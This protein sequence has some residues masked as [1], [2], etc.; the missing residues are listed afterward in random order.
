MDLATLGR[1]ANRWGARRRGRRA[2]RALDE[3]IEHVADEL[4]IEPLERELA[5]HSE[6]LQALAGEQRRGLLRRSAPQPVP[7]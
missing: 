1:L 4:V 3:R 5:T 7:S 2:R 6:L